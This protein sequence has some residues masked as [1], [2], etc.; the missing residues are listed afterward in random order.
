MARKFKG[1]LLKKARQKSGLTQEQVTNA[2]LL[3]DTQLSKYERGKQ[4]PSAETLKAICDYI[5]IDIN[6]LF[7]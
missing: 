7:E 5:G 4:V 1:A 2:L 3:G 6:T